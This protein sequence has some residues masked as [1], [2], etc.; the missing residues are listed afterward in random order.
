M[1][2]RLSRKTALLL[3][4]P[5]NRPSNRT[6]RV[7]LGLTVP[8]ALDS[9]IHR[10]GNTS[11]WFLGISSCP[12]IAERDMHTQASCSGWRKEVFWVEHRPIRCRRA[13]QRKDGRRLL[14]SLSPVTAI[15]A[16]WHSSLLRDRCVARLECRFASQSFLVRSSEDQRSTNPE[17][18]NKPYDLLLSARRVSY[19]LAESVFLT[20]V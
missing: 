6:L 14:V 3:P 8:P 16:F 20:W 19:P 15:N 4:Q 5:R 2:R 13:L 1:Q 10:K 18:H 17:L 12:S 7:F 9:V 11:P